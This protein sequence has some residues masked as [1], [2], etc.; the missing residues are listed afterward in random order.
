MWRQATAPSRGSSSSTSSYSPMTPHLQW[1]LALP[2]GKA[3]KPSSE[4]HPP[5][6]FNHL[7]LKKS[8]QISTDKP[9]RHT[10]KEIQNKQNIIT[11]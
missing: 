8:K 9:T 3:T 6:L 1:A 2:F 7:Q 5:S 10:Y 4:P 11:K